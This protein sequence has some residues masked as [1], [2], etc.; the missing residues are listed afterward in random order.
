MSVT[1]VTDALAQLGASIVG[2]AY[3]GDVD[4]VC[5]LAAEVGALAVETQRLEHAEAARLEEQ[6]RASNAIQK[7]APT[8]APDIYRESRSAA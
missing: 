3:R 7:H 1:P 4:E 2:A 8:A 6:L 5:R